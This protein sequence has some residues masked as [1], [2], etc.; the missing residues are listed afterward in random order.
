MNIFCVYNCFKDKLG[1][2]QRNAQYSKCM[3]IF[4]ATNEL[5]LYNSMRINFQKSFY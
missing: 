4:F 3:Y 5:L 2:E 1:M